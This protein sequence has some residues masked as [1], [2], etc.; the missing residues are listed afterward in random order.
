MGKATKKRECPA[1]ERI[2][3]PAECG[4]NRHSSYKCPEFC[5]F[6]PFAP[7]NYESLLELEDKV[8]LQ[9]LS[10]LKFLEVGIPTTYS[11]HNRELA[12]NTRVIYEV[13]FRKRSED[14]TMAEKWQAEGFPGLNNDGKVLFKGKLQMR[15][16]LLELQSILNDREIQGIDLLEADPQP[17]RILDQNSAARFCRFDR[18]LVFIYP[19]PHYWRMSGFGKHMPLFG[20]I[21]T[22]EAILPLLRLLDAPLQ[23]P[24]SMHYWFSQNFAQ[25]ADAVRAVGIRRLQKLE[26][27]VSKSDPSYQPQ[28]IEALSKKEEALIPPELIT[29]Q[30]IAFDKSLEVD[31]RE[32][33]KLKLDVFGGKTAR[34]ALENPAHRKI[35]VEAVKQYIN[36]YDRENLQSGRREDINW[37]PRELGLEEIDFPPPPDRACFA[38]AKPTD[39]DEDGE[40]SGV[41][42]SL[43]LCPPLNQP[44]YTEADVERLFEKVADHL[45]DPESVFFEM[46]ETG[47]QLYEMIDHLSPAE[48]SDDFLDLIFT[49]LAPFWFIMVPPRH[50]APNI[51]FPRITDSLNQIRS[52]L[53]YAPL[54]AIENFY[55][56]KYFIGCPQPVLLEIST[57]ALVQNFKELPEHL[58]E[59][60]QYL[61]YVLILLRVLIDELDTV[62]RELN[63]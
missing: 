23:D 61:P 39:R 59:Y 14:K 49:M 18:V 37:L 35:V 7:E 46:E 1:I 22:G 53:T 12:E 25:L 24:A 3:S 10:R 52:S 56:K 60:V 47:G 8:D 43:P 15:F 5:P 50:R 20:H 45:P 26:V 51:D 4:T 58:M 34:E 11:S 62:L 31:P 41:D 36:S 38:N 48:F 54:E 2:I 42:L 6:N 27:E 9:T 32:W 29:Q 40:L 30:S 13:F 16:V 33:L 57:A 44:A 28:K 63:T 21:P 19:L 17:L 55:E